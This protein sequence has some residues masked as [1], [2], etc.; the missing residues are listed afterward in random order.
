M[1]LFLDV[2]GAPML[3]TAVNLLVR[4]HALAA[5]EMRAAMAAPHHVLGSLDSIRVV[6]F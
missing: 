4:G 3:I 5:R 1:E 2:G 6:F